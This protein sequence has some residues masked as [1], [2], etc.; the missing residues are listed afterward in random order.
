MNRRRKTA[1][2]SDHHANAATQRHATAQ[3]HNPI[4]AYERE[5][6]ATYRVNI[7]PH[8]P[9]DRT[10]E[11]LEIAAKKI[12]AIPE[13]TNVIRYTKHAAQITYRL[14]EGMAN[15]LSS[16]DPE[17]EGKAIV[18][19][20]TGEE[21]MNENATVFPGWRKRLAEEKGSK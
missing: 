17:L 4:L 16:D 14:P 1:A 11:I 20:Y 10:W 3:A 12:E 13:A 21:V 9:P 6:L 2:G 8:E 15:P 7:L 18:Q 19:L 5:R